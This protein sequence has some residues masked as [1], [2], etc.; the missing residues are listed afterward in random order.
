MG[1]GGRQKS[2]KI[3][4]IGEYVGHP[5]RRSGITVDESPAQARGARCRPR[6]AFVAVDGPFGAPALGR[7]SC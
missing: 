7:V 1:S 6:V 5:W 3:V 4:T 2:R